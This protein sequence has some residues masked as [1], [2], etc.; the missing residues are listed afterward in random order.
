MKGTKKMTTKEMS[1]HAWALSG[2]PVKAA[3]INDLYGLMLNRIA[4]TYE[5]GNNLHDKTLV[6]IRQETMQHVSSLCDRRTLRLGNEVYLCGGFLGDDIGPAHLWLE[7]HTTIKTY[8]T[9]P[10]EVVR[11]VNGV[12]AEDQPFR[13]GYGSIYG[14]EQIARVPKAGYT[15]WQQKSF[16][17]F[18][19]KNFVIRP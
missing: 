15:K 19:F 17:E 16:P 11:R 2:D 9:E 12:G 13:P 4:E 7:D 1:C 3:R 6:T 5:Y 18:Q 8:D 14:Q 10:G